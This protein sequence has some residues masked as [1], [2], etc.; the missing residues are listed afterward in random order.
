VQAFHFQQA[1]PH[2]VLHGEKESRALDDFSFILMRKDPPFDLP[3]YFACQYLNFAKKAKVLNHPLALMSRVE[4]LYPYLFPGVF[5]PVLI[6]SKLEDLQNFLKEYKEVIIKP[7]NDRGGSGVLK[8]TPED[9]NSLSAI[10]ILTEG[11]K[12]EAV[13]QKY[14]PQIRQ[15]D[16]R[17]ILIN[18]EYVGGILRVPSSNDNRTNLHIGGKAQK[19][20]LSKRQKEIVETVLVQLKKDQV[21]FAG[22][23]LIGDYLTE[24]NI[25]SPTGLQAMAKVDDVDGAEL[26]WKGL[27]A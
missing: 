3:Y 19:P 9:R 27:L 1:E 10:E 20:N 25:T 26:F 21:Y 18:Y 5:P 13:M 24:I 4:K 6:S 11:G 12:K 14:L 7:V 16:V 23:D 8:L 2:Y 15:G 22:L 17:A